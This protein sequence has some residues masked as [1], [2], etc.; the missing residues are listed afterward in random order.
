MEHRQ[1]NWKHLLKKHKPMQLPAACDALTAKLI[2]Q[3]GFPAYQVGGFALDE[4]RN[5]AILRALN[6]LK[7][8]KPMPKNE[9]VTMM[10]FEKIV[11]IAYWK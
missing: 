2:Q 9:S 10:D 8:G 4:M 1:R 6:D 11:D 7:S 3:S 5:H